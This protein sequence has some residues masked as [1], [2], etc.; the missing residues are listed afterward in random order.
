MTITKIEFMCDHCLSDIT[1]Y[2]EGGYTVCSHP[3]GLIIKGRTQYS[4]GRI[5]KGLMGL[6]SHTR[7]DGVRVT[8]IC[9]PCANRI[10]HE[11]ERMKFIGED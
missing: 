4:C 3:K 1:D 6:R 2:Q 5:R 11:V 7:T 10:H 8:H 9:K